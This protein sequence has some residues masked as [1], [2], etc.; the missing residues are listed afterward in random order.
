MRLDLFHKHFYLLS[1]FGRLDNF[2][3]NAEAVGVFSKINELIIDL[4]KN[5]SSLGFREAAHHFLDNM[6]ALGILLR[7]KEQ[8]LP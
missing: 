4:F 6:S 8:T 5:E 1:V 7:L 2:L 3:Y